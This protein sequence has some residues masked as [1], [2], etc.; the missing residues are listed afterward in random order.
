MA[1]KRS[2]PALIDPDT[3]D[4]GNAVE[5]K[6]LKAV[7]D[8]LKSVGAPAALDLLI[9]VSDFDEATDS[10]TRPVFQSSHS[11]PSVESDVNL[12]ITPEML[13]LIDPNERALIS[14][15]ETKT[16]YG[17]KIGVGH[18]MTNGKFLLLG[19]PNNSYAQTREGETVITQLPRNVKYGTQWKGVSRAFALVVVDTANGPHIIRDNSGKPQIFSLKMT[20]LRCRFGRMKGEDKEV[21]MPLLNK[22]IHGTIDKMSRRNTKLTWILNLFPVDLVIDPR[23]AVSK[24]N[25]S[26]STIV[27]FFK[28]GPETLAAFEGGT[29]PPPLSKD[30]QILVKECITSAEWKELKVKPF[31]NAVPYGDALNAGY[32]DEDESENATG[33]IPEATE[34]NY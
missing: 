21:T 9:D 15:V 34:M 14:F 25:S 1:T 4:N 12:I 8:T 19:E 6:A 13:E 26:K 23:L 18:K 16:V 32:E 24:K 20:S 33:Q 27:P 3:S 11:E 2:T 17:D 30:L 31:P 5:G 29:L 10:T 28:F 22:W 7:Q